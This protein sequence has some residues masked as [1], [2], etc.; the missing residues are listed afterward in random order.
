[1]GKNDGSGRELLRR[2]VRH[3]MFLLFVGGALGTLLRYYIGHWFKS[4]PWGQVFPFGT[5]IINVAGSFILAFATVVIENRVLPEHADP[6]NLLICIG[7][8]GGFTT[9]STFEME[10]YRLIALG[11]WL[12]ALGNVFGSVVAGF[13]GIVVGVTLGQF[14]FPQG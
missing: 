1:M 7:F 10:T 3:K 9:F 14:L 4:H 13:A 6:M 12:Y 11:S 2:V 5:L 8:C